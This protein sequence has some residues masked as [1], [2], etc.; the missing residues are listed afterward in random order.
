MNNLKTYYFLL[1]CILTCLHL[2]AQNF[3]G[4]IIHRKDKQPVVSAS[5]LIRETQQGVACN[6]DGEFQVK[7][8]PGTYHVDYR[9]LGFETFSE[10]IRIAAGEKVFR[11]I[12]LQAKDFNLKEVVVSN[13]ED[14]AYEIMRKAIAK[15]PFYRLIVKEYEADCYI[16]GNMELTKVNKMLDKLS[17]DNSGIKTSEYKDKLFVQES[18]S[19]VRFSSPDRYE[20]TVKAFKSSLPDDK[21]PKG[22]M[23]VFTG[24]LYQPKFTGCISPLNPA[25]FNY[26]KFRYEGFTEENGENV[27]KIKVMPKLKDPE[28][29]S[30]YLYI[31]DNSWDIRNAELETHIYGM[32]QHFYIT[33]SKLDGGVFL[34][35]SFKNYVDANIIGYGGN[36]AYHASVKYNKVILNDSLRQITDYKPVK[37]KKNLNLTLANKDRYVKTADTLATKRDTSFWNE[38]RNVPLNAREMESFA[39]KDSIQQHLDSLRKEKTNARFRPSDVLQGGQVGGDSTKWTFNYG[40]VIGALRDYNFVDG[41]GIGQRF[42]LSR[43]VSPGNKWIVTPEVYY[44]TARKAILWKTNLEIRYAPMQIGR[45]SFSFG[46]ISADFNPEGPHR[47]DNAYSSILYQKNISMFY[48][49]K[50]GEINNSIDLSNGLRLSTGLQFAKRTPLENNTTFAFF[51]KAE[52]ISKN[53]QSP[54]YSSLTSCAVGLQYTPRYYYRV[55]Q[56]SK[57]Y[58]HS[59]YPTF[60]LTYTEAFSYVWDNSARYSRLEAAITQ[61]IKTSLFSNVEYEANGGVF[62]GNSSRMNLADYKFFN[63][64]GDFYLTQKNPLTTFMLLNPYSSATNRY[65]FSGKIGYNSKYILLKY[66]PFLQGKLFNESVQLKY[67]YTPSQKNYMEAGYYIDFFKAMNFGV[68]ISFDKM[69]YDAWG[70]RVAIPISFGNRSIQISTQ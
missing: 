49:K 62:M 61:K 56:D 64:S 63:T 4:K 10:T 7:L 41:F 27:N 68:N 38:I 20:Q 8:K 11:K 46:D 57:V 58:D 25:A 26:Y 23:G 16:K 47:L 53:I 21:N 31:A 9:C 51:K 48:R 45:L 3:T 28:L 12:E 50:Y 54:A 1:L 65:W 55:Q 14:P 44:T 24:S 32:N 42:S 70:I 5:V 59:D 19:T 52:N 60:S 67:L 29:F 30:G 22:T 15:A 66:L 37:Q 33:Y 34:P 39:K 17:K 40:G 43:N 35:T 13:N 2:S 69:K 36:F 18:Y 6:D